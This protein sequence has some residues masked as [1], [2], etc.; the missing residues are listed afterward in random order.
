MTS[1]SRLSRLDTCAVSDALD[2]LK[3]PGTVQGIRPLTGP[4]RIAGRVVT[5]KLVAGSVG[6]APKRH[7][8]T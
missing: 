3:E 1:V 5:V 7:L 2:K 6:A 8:C 4:A